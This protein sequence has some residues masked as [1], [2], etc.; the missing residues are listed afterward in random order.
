ME[1]I[2]DFNPINYT[3][4]DPDIMDLENAIEKLSTKKIDTIREASVCLLYA[5]PVFQKDFSDFKNKLRQGIKLISSDPNNAIGWLE[6]LEE[7]RQA[8]VNSYTN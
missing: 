4:K 1:H 2:N 3:N 8:L 7:E 5:A 6:Y